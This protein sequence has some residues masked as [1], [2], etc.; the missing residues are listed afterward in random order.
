MPG[1]FVDDLMDIGQRD[2]DDLYRNLE[3]RTRGKIII[4]TDIKIGTVEKEIE[5]VCA[6]ERPLA[7]VMG[8]RSGKSL[9]RALMGSSIFHIMNHV[10]F[11][12]TYHSRTGSLPGD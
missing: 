7:V 8:M 12:D 2:M 4:T 9:E 6:K 10:D 1:D 11:P 3:S 5:M